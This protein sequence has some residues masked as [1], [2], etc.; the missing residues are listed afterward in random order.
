MLAESAALR[1]KLPII[2]GVLIVACGIGSF[3]QVQHWRDSESLFSNS[4]RVAP[5]SSTAHHYL[6][7]LLDQRGKTNE[8][9]FQFTE[10]V[11]CNPSNVTAR[12]GLG[13]ALMSA[14][15]L[16]EAAQ[17][18]EAGLQVEPG[19][20]KAHYA[21]A[22][23]YVKMGRPELAI[24]HY[25][26]ALQL[27][28]MIAGAHYQLGTAMLSGK[29]DPAI[30]VAYLKTAVHLEPYWTV[31]LNTLAWTLAT[32]QDAKIRD[33]AD[34]VK[35]ATRA[36]SI[37]R[38][39]DAGFLDTLAAAYAESGNFTNATYA[40]GR[41]MQVANASGQTNSIAEFQT[42]LKSFQAQHPWRE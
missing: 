16:P 28:P 6:G 13:Y 38:G 23:V 32:H 26:Q 25:S 5:N 36:V 40:I 41:A 18:Y 29:Q 34:A 7:V 12:G 42:H 1:S 14:N 19:N 11:R 15:R 30:A 35:L 10:A 21:L 37:T 17:Q 31:A 8:A 39:T 24:P 3:F 4:L 22:D 33:G 20:A 27:N 2:F 9:L